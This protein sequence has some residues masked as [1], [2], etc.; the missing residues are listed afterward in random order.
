[1]LVEGE[2]YIDDGGVTQGVVLSNSGGK[3]LKYDHIR[4]TMAHH[5]WDVVQIK[6]L[7]HPTRA[8]HKVGTVVE[9]VSEEI[10]TELYVSVHK[11]VS[12]IT[13]SSEVFPALFTT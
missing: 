1:M 10:W 2:E 8:R 3:V 11:R 13:N 7:H 5:G 6:V 9:T 4:V 12:R